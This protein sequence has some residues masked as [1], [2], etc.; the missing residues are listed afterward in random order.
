MY[1][2]LGMNI[3]ESTFMNCFGLEVL[4]KVSVKCN[5]FWDVTL[6]I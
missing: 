6:C 2:F 5:N 3:P 4:I 1:P